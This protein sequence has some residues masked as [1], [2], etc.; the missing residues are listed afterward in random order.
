MLAQSLILPEDA[1]S[2]DQEGQPMPQTITT[3]KRLT[4]ASIAAALVFASAACGGDDPYA[5]LEGKALDKQLGGE[6]TSG[7]TG[8]RTPDKTETPPVLK[9]G[10]AVTIGKKG[11]VEVAVDDVSYPDVTNRWDKPERGKTFVLLQMTIRNNS[12]KTVY[13]VNVYPAWQAEDGRLVSDTGWAIALIGHYGDKQHSD[14]LSDTVPPRAYV[15]G[16]SMYEIPKDEAGRLIF[17]H[18]PGTWM[19]AVD[20]TS[21][22]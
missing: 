16:W 6:S 1:D 13:G 17:P 11:Q 3:V 14:E 9:E 8:S 5:D 18:G 4:V 20:P 7:A 15:R 10:E 19:V 22:E 2:Q 21:S 12:N